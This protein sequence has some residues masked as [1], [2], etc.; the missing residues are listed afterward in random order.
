MS[1]EIRV[2]RVLPA[3]GW[4][5]RWYPGPF[6][7][8]AAGLE[9]SAL[10][11][12]LWS[13]ETLAA[14]ASRVV[15]GQDGVATELARGLA[16]RQRRLGGG[17]PAA[18]A[19]LLLG[20]GAPA[21]VAG[22]QP[23]LLGGPLLT[24][25]KAVT[26]VALARR[27]EAALG[28]RVVPVFWVASDDHDASEAATVL[29]LDHEGRGQPLRLP[30]PAD[31]RPVGGLPVPPVAL[32][33]LEHAVAPWGS[34]WP[35][36]AEA[37]SLL[38]AATAGVADVAEGFGRL[39]ARLLGAHGLVVLD[40]L[41][42]EVRLLA[43]PRL[44]ALAAASPRLAEAL[45]DGEARARAA[46][47]PAPWAGG[48]APLFFLRE[49]GR[50][51][52][53]RWRDGF[54]RDRHGLHRLAPAELAALAA[55]DGVGAAAPT[56]P[57][58][59]SL[60]LPVLGHVVG[61]GEAAYL[62]QCFPAWQALGIEPFLI[63]PRLSLTL[64]PPEAAC[65]ALP[66]VTPEEAL[67]GEGAWLEEETGWRMSEALTAYR[68]RLDAALDELARSLPPA[69]PEASRVRDEARRRQEVLSRRLAHSLGRLLRR[70]AGRPSPQRLA[71]RWF[72][73]LGQP[74]E[75]VL[76]VATWLARAGSGLVECLLSLP[77]GGPHRFVALG[78][79]A[80]GRE[81]AAAA[82]TEGCRP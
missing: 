16:D 73:P 61:P 71:A 33:A 21:V 18:Q 75:K 37:R 82:R 13:E 62:V 23:G 25:Y 65:A 81:R 7:D 80:A 28:T 79:P 70:A 20:R 17:E 77:P 68:E 63:H 51:I 40:P 2:E 31:G 78:V 5:A 9:V 38:L 53:L 72:F 24:L 55:R 46:G 8:L 30:L 4:L 6:A 47:L 64:V 34:P 29:F 12:R 10:G 32:Q 48:D 50:R 1:G 19:A 26:A 14:A 39:L 15:R 36:A 22:Q 59:E 58:L 42:P 76:G 45:A 74:Q 60:L 54:L 69:V 66:P 43:A 57:L 67:A 41:W 52:G 49:G 35:R 11:F 44:A 27:A 3:S 56:R